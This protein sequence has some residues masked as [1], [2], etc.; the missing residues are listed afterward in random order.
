MDQRDAYLL[1]PS[2]TVLVNQQSY[3][4]VLLPA[5]QPF[6][7]VFYPRIDDTEAV[8]CVR[9]GEGDVFRL[10]LSFDP[11][12]EGKSRQEAEVL[13]EAIPTAMGHMPLGREHCPVLA[14][15]ALRIAIQQI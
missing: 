6:R 5:G 4:Q 3:F 7:L 2:D 12:M 1:G 9:Q 13:E 15:E 8:E 10:D 14:I 11:Q